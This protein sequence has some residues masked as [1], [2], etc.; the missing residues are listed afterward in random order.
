V[1]PVVA[2]LFAK[3]RSDKGITPRQFGAEEIQRR[4]MLALV[5]EAALLLADGVAERATDVDV[6][7]VNGDG[8]PRWEGGPVFW[9]RERGAVVLQAELDEFAALSGRGFIR[10]DVRQLLEAKA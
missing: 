7:L 5:N 10:S 8:F 1:E 6:V 2:E 9:A 3:A 4:V